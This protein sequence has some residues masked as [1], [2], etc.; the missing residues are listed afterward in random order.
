M[1]GHAEHSD[2]EVRIILDQ[3]QAGGMM[4]FRRLLFIENVLDMGNLV[5]RNAMQV[6]D[7]VQVL[8]IGE[9]AGENDTIMAKYRYSRYPVIR[10]NEECPVG[11]VHVKDLLLARCGGRETANLAGFIKPC[12]KVKESDSL[13][14]V[15]AEMQRKG[16]HLALVFDDA[17]CWSGAITLEDILEEVVGTIEEEYPVESAIRLKSA[18]YSPGLVIP[19]AQGDTILAAAHNA[20]SRVDSQEL[21]LSVNEI[22]PHIAEREHTGSSYVGRSLAIPHARLRNIAKPVVVFARLKRPIPAPTPSSEDV[23]RYLFILLT[24]SGAP[25]QHQILLSRI[26]G[27]FESGYLEARLEDATTARE[28]YEAIVAVEQA[29]DMPV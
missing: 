25:R 27:I 16:M 2:Q 6:R 22:M 7:R 4:S 29:T 3:S 14:S 21:P 17:S 23:I 15:L 26:A 18:L 5:V 9:R 20:L 10:D 12:M 8:R 11:F 24:P 28:L 13:E 1:R 19:D